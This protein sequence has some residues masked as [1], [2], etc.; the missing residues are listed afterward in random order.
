MDFQNSPTFAR[1]ACF[2]M[3]ISGNFEHFQY[4]NFEIDFMENENLFQKTEVPLFQLEAL[5]LK[6]H[7]LHAKLLYQ[8]PMLRQIEW[9]VQ[10]GPIKKNAVLPVTA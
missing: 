7:H 5:R 1:S 2:Y 8:K 9:L 3:T 4:V 6:T 10:N